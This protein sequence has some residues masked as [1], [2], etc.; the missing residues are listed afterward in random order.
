MELNTK[1]NLYDR[2]YY[3]EIDDSLYTAS[4]TVFKVEIVGCRVHQ[5]EVVYEVQIIARAFSNPS[6]FKS[7]TMETTEDNLFKSIEELLSSPQVLALE[8]TL[9][10]VTLA[11]D[12]VLKKTK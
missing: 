10:K 2:L 11:H 6:S 7:Y 4:V 5:S 9:D 1:Y 12:K 3:L 8:E